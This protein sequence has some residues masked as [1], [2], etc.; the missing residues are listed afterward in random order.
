MASAT[1]SAAALPHQA[2]LRVLV[3]GAGGREH[4]I[5]LHLLRSKRVEHVFVAPGN[6]G[7]GTIAPARC[8]NLTEVKAGGDFSEIAQWAKANKVR[9]MG[10]ASHGFVLLGRG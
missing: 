4:A 7:T 5:A 1:A 8:T 2:P 9:G 3:L 6:G 10:R